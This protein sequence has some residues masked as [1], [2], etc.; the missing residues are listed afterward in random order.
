MDLQVGL[1]LRKTTDTAFCMFEEENVY[2]IHL[3][4]DM[5]QWLAMN[6]VVYGNDPLHS[7][8]CW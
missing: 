8:M 3:T 7:T 6:M 1:I 4:Q 2:W 5:G